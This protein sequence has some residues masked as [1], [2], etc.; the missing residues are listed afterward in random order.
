MAGNDSL[1]PKQYTFLALLL[2]PMT[3]T[4]A[5]KKAGIAERTAY[6]WVNDP[7]FKQTLDASQANL[8]EQGMN[9]LKSKFVNAVKTLDSNLAAMQSAD[10][11][12]AAKIIIEQ[13]IANEHLVDRIASLEAQVAQQEQE[14][15]YHVSFDLRLL[16]RTERD[17]IEA[18]EA[19][20]ESERTKE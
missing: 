4:E 9:A 18:M 5:A 16:T 10:Q 2:A 8:F 11:I 7:I 12:R 13:T 14:R 15:L 19:R 20:L 6:R 17:Q 1:T 3:I